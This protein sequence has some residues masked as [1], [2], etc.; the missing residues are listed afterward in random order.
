VLKRYIR[1]RL[2]ASIFGMTL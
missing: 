2:R 1:T